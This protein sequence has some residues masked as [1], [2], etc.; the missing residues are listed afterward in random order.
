MTYLTDVTYTA[1][2]PG[3][4]AVWLNANQRIGTVVKVK[5]RWVAVTTSPS[6]RLGDFATMSEAGNRLVEEDEKNE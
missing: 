2:Y 1:E 4:Y 6:R 3:T 5:F